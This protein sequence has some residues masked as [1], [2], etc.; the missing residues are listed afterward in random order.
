MV[1]CECTCFF[2]WSTIL[3]KVMQ[4]Y[5]KASLQFQHKQLCKNYKNV[6]IMDEAKNKYHVIR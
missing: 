6:K 3:D 4:N 5:I 2:H 1:G